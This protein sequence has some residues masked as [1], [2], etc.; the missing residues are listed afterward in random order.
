VPAAPA[1]TEPA[2]TTRTASP[3]AAPATTD[4]P[5]AAPS[6]AVAKSDN[7]KLDVFDYRAS[8][9]I[10]AAVLDDHGQHVAKVDDIIVSTEDHKLHAVVAIGGFLGF[11]AK[12]I[13]IPFD[14]LQITA[15][16]NDSQ[17][18][19]KMTGDQ[20]QQLADSRAPFRYERQVAK[21][22]GNAPRG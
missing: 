10:G 6:A 18:R 7:L 3:A 4:R 2:A 17:V 19:V 8:D 13:S 1:R 15:A 14:E 16:G 11:G 21:A 12:L 5:R 20:L 22:P 9:L